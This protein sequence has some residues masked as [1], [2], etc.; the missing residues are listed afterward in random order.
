MVK[1]V[2]KNVL[3]Q[4]SEAFIQTEAFRNLRS[5][6]WLSRRF[7]KRRYR[8]VFSK[9]SLRQVFK[10]GWGKYSKK[11]W[12]EYS[13]FQEFLGTKKSLRQVFKKCLSQT[14]G[15]AVLVLPATLR[16]LFK[17]SC[18]PL[19]FFGFETLNSCLGSNDRGK[20]SNKK[21]WGRYS[22]KFEASI[23]KS[24]RQVFKKVWASEVGERTG[25][26]GLVQLWRHE[27]S[28]T[29]HGFQRRGSGLGLVVHRFLRKR[30]NKR[31]ISSIEGAVEELCTNMHVWSKH[32]TLPVTHV[33]REPMLCNYSKSCWTI[34]RYAYCRQGLAWVLW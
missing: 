18:F 8:G 10:K 30:K 5:K 29:R 27:V 19:Y 11:V 6:S 13:S 4:N 17:N 21:V 24:L 25:C 34:A 9:K 12:G 15:D 3:F 1:Y 20:Y 7:F 23:Q 14:L 28:I 22:K 32:V 16:Q 2:W 31:T 26:I 33:W